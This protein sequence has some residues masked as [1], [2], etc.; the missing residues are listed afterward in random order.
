MIA[1]KT[2]LPEDWI[3]VKIRGCVFLKKKDY[4]EIVK[5]KLLKE[6]PI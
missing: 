5:I 3:R 6:K 1:L 4:T 2:G